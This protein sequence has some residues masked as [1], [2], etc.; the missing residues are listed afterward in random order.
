VT[1]VPRP[2]RIDAV[3]T[4]LWGVV[5]V[6]TI[7]GQT[8]A[9]EAI[10]GMSATWTVAPTEHILTAPDTAGPQL[11]VLPDSTFH[12]TVAITAHVDSLTATTSF[13]VP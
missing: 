11:L 10:A 2:A 6:A 7:T 3:L 12:G 4:L 9:G 8:S 13:D 5:H 1:T